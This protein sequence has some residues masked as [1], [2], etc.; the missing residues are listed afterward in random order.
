MKRGNWDSSVGIPRGYGVADQLELT[1][2]KRTE[3]NQRAMY[4]AVQA[5]ITATSLAK[6]GVFTIQQN[7]TLLPTYVLYQMPLLPGI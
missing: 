3:S 7:F 5:L 6:F 2:Y 1:D 4:Q